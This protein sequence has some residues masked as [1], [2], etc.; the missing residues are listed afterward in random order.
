MRIP[1]EAGVLL[2]AEPFPPGLSPLEEAGGRRWL[3]QHVDLTLCRCD[4]VMWHLLGRYMASWFRY[5]RM[6]GYLFSGSRA[7][8]PRCPLS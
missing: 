3:W 7:P 1:P 5:L 8:Q 6:G 4:L 2:T